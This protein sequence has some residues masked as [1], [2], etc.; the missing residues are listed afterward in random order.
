MAG[1]SF[2]V[3]IPELPPFAARLRGA[4]SVLRSEL[5][6]AMRRIVIA[7]Q[8]L[9]RGLAP[10]DTGRLRDSITGR[11]TA[12]GGDVRGS[13]GTSL[14]YA[15]AV[16]EGRR[17]GAPMPPQGALLG[18]MGRHGIEASL[19]FVVRRAIG[20]RGTKARWFLRDAKER[21]APVVER[22]LSA[23]LGRALDRIGGGR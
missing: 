13:W 23:G 17:A 21:V 4:Q 1:A 19:E 9:S 22:E 12:V 15:E 2:S 8:T 6:T 20:R 10:V 11:V 14:P 7:G 18:W 5:T 16:E 3:E